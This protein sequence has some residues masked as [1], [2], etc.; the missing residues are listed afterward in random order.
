M[1]AM[2]DIDNKRKHFIPRKYLRG[3][4]REERP[5]QICVFDKQRPELGVRV[6]S[7]NDVEVSRDA[8][9][10]ANDEVLTDF[11]SRFAFNLG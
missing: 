1:T 8:Y 2:M 11:E 5:N 3:F 7:I 6:I 4:C 10:V 9:S